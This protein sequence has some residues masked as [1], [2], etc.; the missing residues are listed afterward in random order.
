MLT[1]GPGGDA[2]LVGRTLGDIMGSE[3][4]GAALH[5]RFIA[6]ADKGGGWVS[7]QQP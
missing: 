5:A 2:A 3:E 4:M 1:P 6:A 7:Y